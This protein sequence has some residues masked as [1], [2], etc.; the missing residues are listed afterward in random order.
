M[1]TAL[2]AQLSQIAAKSTNS[3]NLK[4]QKAAHS[5]SLIFDP[6]VAS[7]QDFDTLYTICAE[8]FQELC[9]LDP[10]FSRFSR[11][12]FSEHSK[13]EERTQRTQQENKELDGVLDDFLSLVSGRLLLRPAIKAVEWLVRRF[14]VHEYNTSSVLF[15]FLPYHT[16]AIFPTL[17]SILPT[18]IPDHFRFLHPYITSLSNPP[19]HTLVYTATNNRNFLTLFNSHV[20]KI[21]HSQQHFHGLL[22]LW[23]GVVTEA[24]S[25]MLD[26]ARSG[27]RAVQ[28]QNEEDVAIR[29]LPVLNEGLP[30][31]KVPELR[32]GC[33][34]LLTILATKA[35]LSDGVL[36]GLMEAV[37]SGWTQDT[38]N[39]GIICLSIL[40][41]GLDEVQLS[42]RVVK[43]TLKVENLNEQ[44]VAA[45]KRYSVG[46]L[47]L[48][49]VLGITS[50]LDQADE[51]D[52]LDFV[53]KVLHARL[54]NNTQASRAIHSILEAAQNV[55][56]DSNENIELPLKLSEVL[57]RLQRSAQVG[58]LVQKTL[59]DTNM[60]LDTLEAKLQTVIR[61]AVEDDNASVEDVD[62]PDADSKSTP[63]VLFDSAIKSIPSRTVSEISF[64]ADGKS[65]IFDDL[66]H[67]FGIATPDSSL[68]EQIT[69]LPLLRAE[70]AMDES[71][72]FSFFIRVWCGPYPVLARSAAL[73]VVAK[74]LSAAS[75]SKKDLQSLFP[76]LVVALADQAKRV[77]R[78]AADVVI[79]LQKLYP[80][81]HSQGKKAIK[82]KL[83]AYQDLY[84]PG[85]GMDDL[86]WL[87]PKEAAKLVHDILFAE[88]EECVLDPHH[89]SRLME[90]G[91]RGT[92]RQKQGETTTT[93]LKSSEKANL[94]SFIAGHIMFTPLLHVKLRLLSMLNQVSKV[95][96]TSRTKTLLPVLEAWISTDAEELS[97]RCK[98]EKIKL[99]DLEQQM[100]NIITANDRE[101]VDLLEQILKGERHAHP[102]TP[103]AALERFRQI[104]PSAKTEV[105]SDIAVL[106]L[107]ASANMIPNHT[108]PESTQA[109]AMDILRSVELSTSV[110][111]TLLDDR[112]ASLEVQEESPAPKRRRTSHGKSVVPNA[113]ESSRATQE[114][115]RL[116]F[117][118][119]L[120]EAATPKNHVPLL[121]GLFQALAR[122]QQFRSKI[123]SD[124]AF[125]Q[126]L[127]LGSILEIVDSFKNSNETKIDS[128][129]VRTDLLVDCIR[130]TNSPEVQNAALLVVSSLATIVPEL[131]LHSV[132]PI[133]TFMGAS[134]LR[135]DD[136]YSVHVI[137][138]TIHQ[139]I[140]PLVDSL[141]QQNRD[142]VAG[143]AELLLSFV[144]AFEHI[145]SHRRL[146]LFTSLVHTLGERDFLFA[147]LAMFVDKYASNQKAEVFAFDLAAQFE[148]ETQVITAVKYLNLVAD[149]WKP[150]RSLS[151]VIL[152]LRDQA[153]DV[154]KQLTLRL[155]SLLRKIISLPT[156]GQ[157]LRTLVASDDETGSRILGVFS[158]LLQQLL[159]LI[160][161]FRED[162]G[163][164]SA[165]GELLES[166]LSLFTTVELLKSI[167]TLLENPD[168]QLRRKVLLAL[169]KRLREEKSGNEASREACLAFMPTLTDVAQ[170]N[171]SASNLR[172]TA[173]ACLDLIL[174]KYGKKDPEASLA[175]A[176]VIA[177]REVLG[178][179]DIG[180]KLMAVLTLASVVEVLEA[181]IIPLIP[182]A[183][184]MVLEHLQFSIEKGARNVEKL[185]NASYSLIGA[186]VLHVPWMIS[187]N[188]LKRILTISYESANK[189]SD[190]QDGD[191]RTPTLRLIARQVDPREVLTALDKS[192]EQADQNGSMAIMEFLSILTT[193]IEKHPKST[194]MK[195]S[196]V[197]GDILLKA[198]GI[199]YSESHEIADVEAIEAN[200]NEVALH[201]IMKMNDTTFRPLFSKIV[202]WACSDLPKKDK[203]GRVRRQTTFFE[204]LNEFFGT[205]QSLVTGYT[206][207]IIPAAVDVLNT[208]SPQDDKHF[209]L[210]WTTTIRA[211]Q[212]T[213]T[214]DQDGFW[215]APSHFDAVV[216]PLLS[217][218]KL[219]PSYTLPT[220]GPI[221][222]HL[223]PAIT[224]LAGAT[225]SPTQQK[226]LN[227]ALMSYLRSSDARVRLAAVKCEVALTEQLG[228]EWLAL[229]PEM[230][231]FISELREDGD[232]DVE[233]ETERWIKVAEGVLGEGLE[234]MLQ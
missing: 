158:T 146:S 137:N 187:G 95:G 139:V 13:G 118:L 23:S 7:A 214:H 77:R 75:D 40:A 197:L 66:A 5:Q 53:E 37:V 222:E 164:R 196:Q 188:H 150:E 205:L 12:I 62:M 52:A 45:S 79:S 179:D 56:L 162:K 17:L 228:E 48:G 219:S 88:V 44:L 172:I 135:Q 109:A 102:S 148:P 145:P 125:V 189:L 43:A 134:V 60:D 28:Q 19:R 121:G 3:L 194:I 234:E 225:D 92:S 143:T 170:D 26:M 63:Q 166:S 207:Y 87:P 226:D 101:G 9:L 11:S 160:D 22:A 115:A 68:I 14:R 97:Q 16:D 173:M 165:C 130:S 32:V 141:R 212:K 71:L 21:C 85:R 61:P 224:A 96:G 193:L 168:D 29:L 163:L 223:I 38:V 202:D 18:T 181:G 142:V 210:L 195:H 154:P 80:S 84:G 231:P 206:S 74:R 54:L 122:A 33:Y 153:L 233:R 105:K 140:P 127:V 116:T 177:S 42:R 81:K 100:V 120:I 176:T 4:A 103:Q 132:M 156:L 208:A 180:V 186:L 98:S 55:D 93:S 57:L 117:V 147:T 113:A 144:A 136:E 183:L 217:S 209:K 111:Q 211:L 47:S 10:R 185:H 49:L 59:E 167:D 110:L 128:S 126:C 1:A 190:S 227:T 36:V 94:L 152:S 104:W 155:F 133:F 2:S 76:Y 131:V 51:I 204:F 86:T 169:E 220:L 119:E 70:S 34:M 216:T 20:L 203:D 230:L 31:K 123:G 78:A 114:F 124:L 191:S 90:G 41:Q 89:M 159:G 6:R 108:C 192:W 199:R 232:E 58:H 184:P 112:L 149:I 171:S 161:T 8:G 30:M 129:I 67:V 151:N 215:Q 24:T 35:K 65:H 46:K 213:F 69:Q 82:E 107:A 64:L 15:A 99:E 83:W 106:L 198:F 138:Q 221:T 182:Q 175:A 157:S 50:R 200:V 178:H 91:L 218:L 72:F 27:R 39:A 201:M 73:E 25:G 174:E 229:L